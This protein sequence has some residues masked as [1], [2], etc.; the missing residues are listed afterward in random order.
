M[1]FV[2]EVAIPKSTALASPVKVTVPVP[3]RRMRR[4]VLTYPAG[5]KGNVGLRITNR[6][7]PIIPQPDSNVQFLRGDTAVYI[8]KFR[9]DSSA[10]IAALRKDREDSKSIEGPDNILEFSG[11]N[12]DTANDWYVTVQIE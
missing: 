1:A 2:Y 10:G 12:L 4:M 11:Y 6:G 5:P 8:I 7:I 3:I 9:A